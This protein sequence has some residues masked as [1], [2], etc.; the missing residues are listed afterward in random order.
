MRFKILLFINREVSGNILPISYQYELSAAINNILTED[1]ENYKQ[2]LDAN[3]L[4]EQDNFDQKLYSLSNLYVPRLFVQEDRM[5]IQVPRVQFWI[6]FHHTN[7][8]QEFVTKALLSRD[9]N[10]G[11]RKS[12]VHFTIESIDLVSPVVYTETMVYQTISPISVIAIRA[13]NSVEYLEPGNPYFAQF[14]IEEL[15]ERWERINKC[16]YTGSRAFNFKLLVP[17]KRKAVTIKVGTPMQKKVIS[18]MLKFEL[19]MD[20]KLQELAYNTGIGNKIHQGF[21]YIELLYKD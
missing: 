19:T 18:Y 9:L 3:G 11:D 15:I 8:T 14:M 6:S 2:W 16:Q 10:I 17:P 4:S 21:G 13:N 20:I 5:T 12:R 7:F 1:K